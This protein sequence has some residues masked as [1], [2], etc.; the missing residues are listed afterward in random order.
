MGFKHVL[1]NQHMQGSGAKRKDEESQPPH[2]T[3]LHSP[4]SDSV[5]ANHTDEADSEKI[6]KAKQLIS[7]QRKQHQQKKNAL[8]ERVEKLKGEI[9]ENER[10]LTEIFAVTRTQSI[11]QLIAQFAKFDDENNELFKSTKLFMDD[12]E[13]MQEQ[14]NSA[15]NRARTFQ[16]QFLN[17]SSLDPSKNLT[18]N[19]S[20]QLPPKNPGR[21]DLEINAMLKKI[22]ETETEGHK[23]EKRTA[24]TKKLL[25]AFRLGLFAVLEQVSGTIG[26]ALNIDSTT[27]IAEL[28]RHLERVANCVVSVT[29]ENNMEK[30]VFETIKLKPE[31]R[32]KDET[33][34]AEE[35]SENE[36]QSKLVRADERRDDKAGLALN[37]AELERIVR[38]EY[39]ANLQRVFKKRLAM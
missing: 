25:D 26:E 37:R 18:L 33:N 28:L 29:K 10:I 36:R 19:P 20:Q 3:D 24:E 39:G 15:I 14:R 12:I 6:W 21:N 8:N 16:M 27:D 38:K 31:E 22:A 4:T 7:L 32:G 35:P 9:Q 30:M 5:P 17:E 13:M 23:I 11:E 2:A 34:D 1:K